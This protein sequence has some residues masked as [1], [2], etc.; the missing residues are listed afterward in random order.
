[1]AGRGAG[2]RSYNS[3]DVAVD[4]RR[5]TGRSLWTN[6]SAERDPEQPVG[7]IQTMVQVLEGRLTSQR[8]SALLLGVFAGVALLLAA[9]E[10]TASSRTSCADAAG[11]SESERRL[12]RGLPTSFVW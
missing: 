10:S 12:A 3:G 2:Q 6:R 1:M 8:F 11:R 9:S 5:S 4:R 7:G